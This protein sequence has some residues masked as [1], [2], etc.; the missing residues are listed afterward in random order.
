M[1]DNDKRAFMRAIRRGPMMFAEIA[2]FTGLPFVTVLDIWAA[3][4]KAGKLVIA[5]DIP[6]FRHV[7]EVA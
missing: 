5:D 1:T 4:F 7:A 2:E 6:G 3:G